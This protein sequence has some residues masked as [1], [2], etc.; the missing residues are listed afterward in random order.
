MFFVIAIVT[1]CFLIYLLD[2]HKHNFW[3][4][5]GFV[6]LSPKFFIGDLGPMIG[7]KLSLGEFFEMLYNKYKQLK[8]FGIYFTYQSN[9]V[10][11]DPLLVQKVF[12]TDFG[13]FTDRPVPFNLEND[14]LQAHLF[15]LPGQQWRDMRVKLSPTFTSGKLKG[16]FPVIKT[17]GETLNEYMKKSV[18]NGVD[19]F[20]FHDLM[21]RFNT[22]IISSVA[23][24]IDNDCINEPDHLFRRMGT[25]MLMP[26]KLSMLIIFF[27]PWIYHRTSLKFTDSE[28]EEFMFSIVK[29]TVDFRASTNFSRNDFMQSLIQLK[30]Q[31]YLS[32][33]TK[34]EGEVKKMNLAE[35]A[36]QA[37]V[38]FQAGSFVNFF[39]KIFYEMKIASF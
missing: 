13:K 23:F 27:A 26:N 21:A 14:K 15:H 9:I 22:N 12:I 33:D 1:F 34:G 8:V 3:R 32:V 30:D 38:F 25:K 19:E 24:G 2:H 17:C 11:T 39:K 31:G 4:R 36:A 20:E 10:V 37:F 6:Q 29:Q 28:V 16:M 18:F 5:R 35:M 7:G